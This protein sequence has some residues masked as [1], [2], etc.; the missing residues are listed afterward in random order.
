MKMESDANYSHHTQYVR[1][2]QRIKT[3]KKKPKKWTSFF[4][5]KQILSTIKSAKALKKPRI[6]YHLKEIKTFSNKTAAKI[7][8]KKNK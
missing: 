6:Q 3:K 1:P 8:C 4:V 5:L 7:L 2:T